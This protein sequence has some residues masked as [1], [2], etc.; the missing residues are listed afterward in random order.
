M[1]ANLRLPRILDQIRREGTATVE[2][3]ATALNV[4]PQTIR[5]D[6]TDLSQS[7]AIERV[8]GGA[9]LRGG[10]VNLAYAQRR[11]LAADA[12]Q[13]IAQ[14][15]AADI[16]H[17]CALFLNIGTTTEA[18]ARALH[19]HGG[20]RVFTNNTNIATELC[21][22]VEVVVTGGS[23]RA[24]D[25]G[26]VGPLAVQAVRQFRYDLAVIGCSAIEEGGDLMDFDL[27]EV[28]VSQA[29][30]ARARQVWVVA[31][32]GKM[33][34]A[35]PARIGALSQAA[36]LYTDA[37]LAPELAALCRQWGTRVVTAPADSRPAL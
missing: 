6:L 7:G 20:L 23:L 25:G 37:P 18:V 2:G 17:N 11:A 35:A 32:A 16:P 13:A 4:T 5:R 12:K 3:L 15:C 30:M 10:G 9:I 8:H 24:S 36:R 14:T 29:I 27:A 1:T 26:L 28:A 19:G 31:D 21:N 33:H 22:H 34:R